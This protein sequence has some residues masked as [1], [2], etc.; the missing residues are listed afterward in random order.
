VFRVAGSEAAETR[1]RK[2]LLNSGF[3]P[4]ISGFYCAVVA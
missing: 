1:D 4:L 3:S 2:R